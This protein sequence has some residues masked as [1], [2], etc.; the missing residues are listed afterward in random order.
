MVRV[1]VSNLSRKTLKVPNENHYTLVEEE[2]EGNSYSYGIL[3]LSRH[4]IL[5]L[6]A[7]GLDVPDLVQMTPEEIRRR[8]KGWGLRTHEAIAL[9]KE[10]FSVWGEE[11]A[12][13]A[14]IGLRRW[15]DVKRK[16]A[17]LIQTSSKKRVDKGYRW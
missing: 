6:D 16:E 12:P 11:W 15:E 3:R 17:R 2:P 1:R 4:T 7:Q 10:I 5:V 14:E 13:R 8:A 9:I